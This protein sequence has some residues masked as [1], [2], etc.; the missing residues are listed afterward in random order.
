MPFQGSF[1]FREKGGGGGGFSSVGACEEEGEILVS[2]L[3]LELEQDVWAPTCYSPREN[4]KI[5]S[6]LKF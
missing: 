4:L 1:P 3:Y 6:E 2:C 5:F